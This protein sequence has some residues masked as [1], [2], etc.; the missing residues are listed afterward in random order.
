[1]LRRRYLTSKGEPMSEATLERV[2]T[3][4]RERQAEAE[5]AYLNLAG[6]IANGGDEPDAGATADILSRAGK[7]LN[8]L[9]QL[10]RTL[11]HRQVLRNELA[12]AARLETE[13]PGIVEQ[14]HELTATFE[15][16]R[17]Q[18]ENAIAP[19]RSRQYTIRQAQIKVARHRATLI[20]E[21]PNARLRAQLADTERHLRDN[22]LKRRE[23]SG[24]SERQP[25]NPLH[26]A[27][28]DALLKEHDELLAERE[29]IEQAMFEH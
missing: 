26:K 4:H 24:K 25:Q 22:D 27:E 14:M 9:R 23:A 16:A 20:H 17:I 13:T 7:D 5:Q 19:L 6:L 12:E 21:C 11:E 28:C 3:K 10:V 2:E 29:R 18:F 15:A 1:M 8:D